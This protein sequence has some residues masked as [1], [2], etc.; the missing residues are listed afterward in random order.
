MSLWNV[1]ITLHVLL[2]VV[3]WFNK[4]L[5][6]SLPCW[7]QFLSWSCNFDIDCHARLPTHFLCPENVWTHKSDPQRVLTDCV[8]YRCLFFSLPL[9]YDNQPYFPQW[10]GS[11]HGRDKSR[12]VHAHLLAELKTSIFGESQFYSYISNLKKK[13]QPGSPFRFV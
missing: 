11:M 13:Q 10:G 9:F 2:F 4:C 5:N 12:L 6:K 3:K 8:S 7:Q 1:R